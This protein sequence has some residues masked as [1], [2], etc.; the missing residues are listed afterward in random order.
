VTSQL[1][2]S[3]SC[4]AAALAVACAGWLASD[5]LL[6]DRARIRSRL[7]EGSGAQPAIA[8]TKGALFK[9]FG[10]LA[11]EAAPPLPGLWSRFQ[12]LLVQSRVPVPPKRLLACVAALVLLMA[13]ATAGL[14]GTW[15]LAL[16]SGAAAGALPLAYLRARYRWRQDKLGRQLPEAFELMARVVRAGQT[17]AGAFQIV[18]QDLR[19]PIAEEFAHCY[20]QQILGRPQELALR[21]LARRTGV[22]ELQ[23]FVVALLVQRRSGGNLVELLHNLSGVVRSR[24]RL[25]GK[26]RAL[27]GEGRLQALVLSMLPI[28]VFV[29]L[30]F[31]NRPYAQILLDQPTVLGAV[32]A[33]QGA[34]ILWIHC[35]VNADY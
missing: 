30:V 27:T 21:D 8:G 3:L 34:G 1:I 26:V 18:A 12:D 33:C 24:I 4:V 5:L 25:K 19:P 20:Q 31:L 22:M 13:A 32:L 17:I 14:G 23:M 15:W 11:M 6:R 16:A 2:V 9:D 10:Q 35:I 7:K 28:A 29:A